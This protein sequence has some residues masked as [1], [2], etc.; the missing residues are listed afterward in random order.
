MTT[1]YKASAALE[2]LVLN[3]APLH[4]PTK[5]APD[6]FTELK[7]WASASRPGD[8]MPVYNGGCDNTIYSHPRYNYAFRAW[9]DQIHLDLDL[10]FGKLAE[11][12]VCNEHVR[13]ARARS[14]MVGL[15][16]EDIR[17]IYCDV[18]GQV[19]YYYKYKEFINDQALFVGA[20][21]E[22]GIFST[23]DSGVRY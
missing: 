20:C 16:D 5:H 6:S 9:H 19:L 11:I 21:M 18:A 14:V 1:P 8:S 2:S 7:G 12:K 17:A 3:M 4:H 23:L 15:N 22:N 13:Q 10:G